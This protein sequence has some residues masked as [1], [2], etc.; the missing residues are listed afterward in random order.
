MTE[1]LQIVSTF[2]AGAAGCLTMMKLLEKVKRWNAEP[3]R[4]RI[5]ALFPNG[6]KLQIIERIDELTQ[7]DRDRRK[8]L[9]ELSS[10]VDRIA[11]ALDIPL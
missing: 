2:A 8:E 4:K 6:E 9:L 10:N 11:R 7:H 5:A 3:E 1:P